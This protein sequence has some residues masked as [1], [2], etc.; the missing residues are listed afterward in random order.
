MRRF[1]LLSL[2]VAGAAPAAEPASGGNAIVVTG[3]SPQDTERAFADCL[4]RTCP[5]DESIDA[6]LA[7]APRRT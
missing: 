7:D 6:G 1:V 2:L 3:R 4:A 5:P